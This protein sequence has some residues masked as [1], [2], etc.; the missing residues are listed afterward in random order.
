MPTAVPTAVCCCCRY[1]GAAAESS[2]AYQRFKTRLQNVAEV[3]FSVSTR[4]GESLG[5]VR[6]L[7]G[8]TRRSNSNHNNHNSSI[9]G[10]SSSVATA[11]AALSPPSYG[12][13]SKFNKQQHSAVSS[14][15]SSSS[16]LTTEQ[17]STGVLVYY[18]GRFIRRLWEGIGESL[19]A[20]SPLNVLACSMSRKRRRGRGQSSSQSAFSGNTATGSSSSNNSNSNSSSG[21]VAGRGDD[22]V[23]RGVALSCAGILIVPCNAVRVCDGKE[24]FVLGEEWTLIEDTAKARVTEYVKVCRK[25]TQ[26]KAWVRGN[27]NVCQQAL[28]VVA[29][30]KTET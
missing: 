17:K 13:N 27:V 10:S 8:L 12:G 11:S 5:E 9:S 4:G 7:L 16:A 21:G 14:S 24:A 3:G 20:G 1:C 26:L 18:R 19:A 22:G 2:V 6:L 30:R 23:G 15:S 29:T 28:A 25:P